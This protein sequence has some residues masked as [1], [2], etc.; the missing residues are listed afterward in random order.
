MGFELWFFSFSFVFLVF[1]VGLDSL[2]P[3]KI[4]TGWMNPPPTS[5]KIIKL[6]LTKHF[7]QHTKKNCEGKNYHEN[8]FRKNAWIRE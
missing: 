7:L 8:K 1:F 5:I 4:K 2:S 3:W 6:N